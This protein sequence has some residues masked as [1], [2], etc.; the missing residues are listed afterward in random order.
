SPI[1]QA[2]PC[3]RNLQPRYWT[4]GAA[5]YTT[6]R[7]RP[8]GGDGEG[9]ALGCVVTSADQALAG[10]QESLTFGSRLRRLRQGAGLTQEMLAERAGLSVAT[11]G[12]LEEGQRRRSHPHTV[13]AL[14]DALGLSNDE[15]TGLL[16]A[17]HESSEPPARRSPQLMHGGQLSADQEP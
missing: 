4:A 13:V 9:R 2:S 12:A 6:C 7:P 10:Q 3:R 11:I 17:A 8:I 1:A 14:A 15:R 16:E 5:G